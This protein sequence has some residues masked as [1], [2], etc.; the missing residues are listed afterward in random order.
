[1]LLAGC[2]GKASPTPKA[3]DA[4]APPPTPTAR[5]C[6][7]DPAVPDADGLAFLN[8]I[9]GTLHIEL[10][11]PTERISPNLYNEKAT[12]T[13]TITKLDLE[14]YKF[15]DDELVPLTPAE[16]G[17]VVFRGAVLQLQ[18][19]GVPVE[20]TAADCEFTVADIV[21]AV[22]ET[23]RR[24]RGDSEWFEGVDVHHHFFE[25]LSGGGDGVW[26][27]DWGS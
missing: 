10:S 18:G 14:V 19:L 3:R 20:H 13:A 21:E 26:E 16:L 9:G 24:T 12:P 6:G 23:E 27:I 7:D 8:D 22:E 4:S 25:G 15:E 2:R 11:E 1:V 5:A 17:R